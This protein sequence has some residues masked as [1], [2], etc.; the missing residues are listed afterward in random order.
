M[1]NGERFPHIPLLLVRDAPPRKQEPWNIPKPLNTEEN[2]KNRAA[3]YGKID[4]SVRRLLEE[5]RSL[6]AD[7]LEKGL[8]VIEN[9]IALFLRIDEQGL[10]IDDLRKYDIEIIA[11]LEDG[12]IIGCSSDLSLSAL[13]RKMARFLDG[14]Q[15]D[16]AG[17]YHIDNGFGWRPEQIL[18]PDLWQRWGEMR[19][20]EMLS[21]DIG[22][23]C[24]GTAPFP[25]KPR[26]EKDRSDKQFNTSLQKWRNKYDAA[27][28]SWDGLQM[29]R[30]N[31]L[32]SFLSAYGFELM[33]ELHETAMEEIAQLPDSFTLRAKISGKCLRDLVINF[34][35]IFDVSSV[36]STEIPPIQSDVEDGGRG[37]DVAVLA[38]GPDAPPS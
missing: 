34:P 36:E 30:S 22:V 26:R 11:E 35:F 37:Q 25:E 10:K 3:H 21:V 29:E 24:L 31:Q 19:D 14:K 20:D 7:R 6:K 23:A 5:D 13:R 1:S 27:L 4:S 12:F 33:D 8:P 15:H 32:Q 16:A 2:L 18:S 28:Q 17:L 9:E 38:P